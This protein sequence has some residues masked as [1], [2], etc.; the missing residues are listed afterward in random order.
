MLETLLPANVSLTVVLL[1]IGISFLTSALTAA[2]GIGGGVA[3]LGALAGS[4]PPAMVVAVHG[5]VQLGSNTGRAILQRTHVLW[6]PTL[7]F[8][9]GSLVGALAGAALFVNLP[10]RLLLILLGVFILIM[11]WIPKPRIPGLASTGMLIG[12]F[13]ATFLTMFVGATGPFV[14]AL[15]LPMDLEKRVLVASHAMCMTIQHGLKVVAFGFLGFAFQDWLPLMIAMIASGFLGTWFGTR[16][17]DK[18]PQGVFEKTLKVLLTL[19]ALDLI[20]RAV[21]KA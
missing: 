2:F 6:R 17:L 7:I 21:M 13:I 14:Q 11:T 15:F 9:V 12:G 16:L 1:L 4:V 18:I 8:S 20:R 3:M 5:I 19:V 10:E